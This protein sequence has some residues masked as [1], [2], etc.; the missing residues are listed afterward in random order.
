MRGGFGNDVLRATSYV[1][2][3]AGIWGDGGN[4]AL[5]GGSGND[6]LRG[7]SGDD[8]LFGGDGND[9]LYGDEGKDRMW[10]QGGTN[11][12]HAQDW[13]FRDQVWARRGDLIADSD[14]V[15]VIHWS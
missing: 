4:D 10:G 9:V 5:Y 11:T 12:F 2:K 14:R 6:T 8:D 1:L 3:P 15:D 13:R 7:G